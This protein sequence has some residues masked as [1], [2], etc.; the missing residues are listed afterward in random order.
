MDAFATRA[1]SSGTTPMF[2]GCNDI[3]YPLFLL[4]PLAL[5]GFPESSF[6]ASLPDVIP[7]V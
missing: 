5:S 3:V 2:S 7:S 1:V 4:A 6:S